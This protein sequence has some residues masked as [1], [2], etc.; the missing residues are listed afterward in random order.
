[1]EQD[2]EIAPFTLKEY[3]EAFALWSRT[4]GMGL[5]AADQ[6]EPI[7]TFLERNPGLSF[8]GRIGGTLVGT[9]L[10]GSDGRRGYLY[11]LAVD[12]GQRRRGL[13]TRLASACLLALASAGIE[14][15]HLFLISG[16]ELGAAFWSALGWTKRDDIIVF[17]KNLELDGGSV[18]R[19]RSRRH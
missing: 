16:N 11:H 5:S 15:C 9:A 8:A 14:K 3:D 17:S 2:F 6:R 12:Q 19:E 4:P 18:A 13:G 7:A 10:C 1:M